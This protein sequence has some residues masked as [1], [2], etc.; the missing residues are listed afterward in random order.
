MLVYLLRVFVISV[1]FVWIFATALCFWWDD[2]DDGPVHSNGLL[3]S[4]D[5]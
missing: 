2:N 4:L 5:S 1:I 3:M